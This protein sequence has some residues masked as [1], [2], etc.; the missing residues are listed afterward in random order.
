MKKIIATGTTSTSTL[1]NGKA[2]IKCSVKYSDGTSETK[3][4]ASYA[5][6]QSAK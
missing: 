3:V 2:G 5:E 1:P 4:F 6:I